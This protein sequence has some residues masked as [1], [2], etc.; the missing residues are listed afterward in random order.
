ML[1]GCFGTAMAVLA[2]CGGTAMA[3]LGGCGGTAMAVLTGCGGTARA[4]LAGCGGTAR[5]VLAGCG[6]TARARADGIASSSFGFCSSHSSD[7]TAS[8]G[9]SMFGARDG[10]ATG[11][12]RTAAFDGEE[13]LLRV[14][15]V[16][17]VEGAGTGLVGSGPV[18]AKA[19]KAVGQGGGAKAAEAVGQGGGAKAAEAAGPGGGA[20]AA[21]AAGQ[22]GGAKP[23]EAAVQA[24]AFGQGGEARQG[25][26]EAFRQGGA[27][28]TPKKAAT[29][30]LLAGE[31]RI[32]G[33]VEVPGSIFFFKMLLGWAVPAE[34]SGSAVFTGCDAHV[35]V[36]P[37]PSLPGGPRDLLAV[38]AGAG[39][40][41]T[42]GT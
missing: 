36:L 39:A 38:A 4:V 1:T 41:S 17:G 26:A 2:G 31:K 13:E 32:A 8:L 30:A 23:V 35:T 3:V 5:A 18:T 20:K 29:S 9:G 19:A 14:M 33:S 34:P 28:G 12:D 27:M 21:E 16:A 7:L 11:R 10:V 25:A 37:L 24:L 40:G 6:G 15:S 42:K 22:G